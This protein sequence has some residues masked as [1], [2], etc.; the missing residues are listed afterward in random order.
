MEVEIRE[1]FCPFSHL[2]NPRKAL[3]EKNSNE[4][5]SG[6][7]ANKLG[8]FEDGPTLPNVRAFIQHNFPGSDQYDSIIQGVPKKCNIAFCS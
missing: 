7:E 6:E 4:S 1:V 2:G 5:P 8:P 3:A